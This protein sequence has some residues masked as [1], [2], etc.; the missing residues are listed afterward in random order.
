[1][2]GA[3]M[4]T[5]FWIRMTFVERRMHAAADVPF[6]LEEGPVLRTQ[7]FERRGQPHVLLLTAHHSGLDF[8]SLDLLLDELEALWVRAKQDDRS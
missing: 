6:H 5:L 4:R 7:L 1:M 3:E 2:V 8:W